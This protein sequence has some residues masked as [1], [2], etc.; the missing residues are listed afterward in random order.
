LTLYCRQHQNW[1][2]IDISKL[3]KHVEKDHPEIVKEVTN[4][5]GYTAQLRKLFGEQLFTFVFLNTT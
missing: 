3:H 1:E 2:G 5:E 4:A